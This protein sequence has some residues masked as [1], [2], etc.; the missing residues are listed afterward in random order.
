MGPNFSQKSPFFDYL[1]LILWD[2]QTL[3]GLWCS[4]NSQNS[5]NYVFYTTLLIYNHKSNHFHS[6]SSLWL[7]ISDLRAPNSQEKWLI[8]LV[9][10][11][12][13]IKINQNWRENSQKPWVWEFETTSLEENSRKK[14]WVRENREFAR[15]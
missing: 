3:L 7:E 6:I 4:Q 11:L 14:R 12:I 2:Y 1:I 9:F 10:L 15:D 8:L 13:S 5:W